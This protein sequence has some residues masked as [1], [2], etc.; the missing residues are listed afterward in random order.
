MPSA[1]TAIAVLLVPGSKPAATRSLFLTRY[2]PACVTMSFAFFV[3]AM[4]YCCA[5]RAA[6]GAV[7]AG[8][9][10]PMR[11]FV[12]KMRQRQLMPG[13]WSVVGCVA[14]AGCVGLA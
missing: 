9:V 11:G 7:A 14:S 13:A 6:S 1:N 2:Q 3:L 5:R 12:I 10:G 4:I 8:A